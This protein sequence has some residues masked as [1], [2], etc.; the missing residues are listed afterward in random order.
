[1]RILINFI[2][3]TAL[4]QHVEGHGTSHSMSSAGKRSVLC[5]EVL[6]V[7]L[8]LFLLVT[9]FEK[10]YPQTFVNTGYHGSSS[11]AGTH[12]VSLGNHAGVSLDILSNPIAGYVN[13]QVHS[14]RGTVA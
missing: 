10:A 7:S 13:V 14:C 8:A 9:I 1:M 5:T 2:I 6:G 3:I 4:C 12:T 11:G